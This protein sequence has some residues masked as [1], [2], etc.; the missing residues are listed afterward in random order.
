[1]KFKNLTPD[2]FKII[3]KFNETFSDCYFEIKDTD[4]EF[5]LFLGNDS[6]KEIWRRSEDIS[7]RLGSLALALAKKMYELKS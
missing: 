2:D 5:E 7:E 6:L 3:P 4:I 1:M